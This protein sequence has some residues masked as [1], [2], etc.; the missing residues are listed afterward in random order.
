MLAF[1]NMLVCR[2][3]TWLCVCVCAFVLNFVCSTNEVDVAWVP[4]C[5][6]VYVYPN[7]LYLVVDTHVY[8]CI[9]GYIIV[10][11]LA[12]MK[13]VGFGKSLFLDYYVQLFMYKY[14]D[15]YVGMDTFFL[16]A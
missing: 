14:S 9:L 5:V 2:P 11:K 13:I 1:V 15:V 6:F 7:W 4:I 10:R 12:G 3:Y 16:C 8:K